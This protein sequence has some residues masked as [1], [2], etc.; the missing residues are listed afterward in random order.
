MRGRRDRV[1]SSTGQVFSYR[2]DLPRNPRRAGAARFEYTDHTRGGTFRLTAL[3]WIDV[4]CSLGS[5]APA[6]RPDT[7][8][9]TGFGTWSEDHSGALHFVAAQISEAPGA[10]YVGIQVD[11]G[12]TSNADTKPRQAPPA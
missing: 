9:F 6:G 4:S 11:G 12:A 3:S 10:P 1:T 2:Y 8:T 7:V 5:T